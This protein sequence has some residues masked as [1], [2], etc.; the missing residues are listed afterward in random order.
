M[1][2]TLIGRASDTLA[3]GEIFRLIEQEEYREAAYLLE[4][5][6]KVSIL[7]ACGPWQIERRATILS[8]AVFDSVEAAFLEGS[9]DSTL[10]LFICSLHVLD[11]KPGEGQVR[12]NDFSD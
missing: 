12:T 5:S 7:N 1:C 9:R 10:L 11:A 6:L 8:R 3:G 2:N 4:T